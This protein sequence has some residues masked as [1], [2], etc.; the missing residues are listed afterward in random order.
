MLWLDFQ[1]SLVDFVECMISAC[2]VGT[3][4]YNVREKISQMC[5]SSKLLC[6]M[7]QLAGVMMIL[8]KF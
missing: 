8:P 2:P 1:P 7:A 3:C 4:T 6:V 5:I